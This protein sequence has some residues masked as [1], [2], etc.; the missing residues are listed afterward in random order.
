MTSPAHATDAGT[1][2]TSDAGTA[3]A[4]SPVL[5]PDPAATDTGSADLAAAEPAATFAVG[6]FVTASVG[7]YRDQDGRVHYASPHS[8][9]TRERLASGEWTEHDQAE[10]EE[11]FDPAGEKVRDVVAYLEEHADDAA[12]VQR[13]KDAEAAGENRPTIA[14]WSPPAAGD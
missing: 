6:G 5:G 4:L 13:V 9:A 1:T 11:P 10:A 12:E 8:K 2:T 14:S 3:A 7:V